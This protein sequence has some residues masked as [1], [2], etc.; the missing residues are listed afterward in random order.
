MTMDGC[1]RD[2]TSR[3]PSLQR[4]ERGSESTTAEMQVDEEVDLDPS[5][6]DDVRRKYESECL[7]G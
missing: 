3:D 6:L 2:C 4:S 5:D 1:Q 7:T